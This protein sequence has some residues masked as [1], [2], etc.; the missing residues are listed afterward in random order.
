MADFLTHMDEHFR[1]VEFLLIVLYLLRREGAEAV[2][3]EASDQER[4]GNDIV[5]LSFIVPEGA[6]QGQA[7]D[8]A[9]IVQNEAGIVRE[10]IGGLDEAADRFLQVFKFSGS[11]ETSS[12]R[13]LYRA[14]DSFTTCLASKV[15]AFSKIRSSAS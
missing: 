1:L 7:F 9:F 15:A 11:A 2:T 5:D 3:C 12:A 8:L 14:S 6:V 4:A 13:V 10:G